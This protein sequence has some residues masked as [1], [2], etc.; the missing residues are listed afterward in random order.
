[1]QLMLPWRGAG[2]TKRL[3]WLSLA[4]LARMTRS[5]WEDVQAILTN[6]ASFLVMTYQDTNILQ[7]LYL[8]ELRFGI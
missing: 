7:K 4:A 5:G 2:N 1:M 8:M 3:D 6:P